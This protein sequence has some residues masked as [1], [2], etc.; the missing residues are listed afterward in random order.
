MKKLIIFI[1][2]VVIGVGGY[3]F[4]R[5]GNKPKVQPPMAAMK[6]VTYTVVPSK[7]HEKI[8]SIGTLE[9]DEATLI[10]SEVTGKVAKIDF[11][12]GQ[13]M[14]QG[15]LILQIEDDS[16]REEL[17]FA[18]AA[19]EL[20]K[21]TFNRNIELQKSGAVA[22]QAKDESEASVR[23]M[24]AEYE[25]KKIR[26][27]KTQIKVPFDGIVGMSPI[28]L[29][30][31]LNVGDPIVNISAIDPL[32]MQF[33]V[34]QKYLSNIKDEEEV[35]ITTDAW[36]GR[37]FKGHISAIDPQIDVDTRN[38]TIKALVPNTE[39]LLR[40]GLF[41]YVDLGIAEIDDALLV[42]EEALIPATDLVTVMKVVDNRAQVARVKVGVRQN[43]M[44]EIKEGL[45]A[46]EVVISAGNL[47]VREGTLVEPISGNMPTVQDFEGKK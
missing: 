12:E 24:E 5:G 17:K 41:S 3:Y 2:I 37:E 20:A 19:F 9:A 22:L 38:I 39:G 21:L 43:G 27:G 25:I 18:E 36:P 6:V 26:L 29:G 16:Y 35:I 1:V 7:L 10:K 11:K 34:P 44:V 32:Y 31:Y 8:G 33:S 42:P 45:E 23:K 46:G 40:P 15:D 47:K 30:A 28:S 14:K 4:L 13:T